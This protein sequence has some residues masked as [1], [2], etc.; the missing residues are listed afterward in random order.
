MT[1]R[2]KEILHGTLL[3]DG[4][5]EDRGTANSRLQIRHAISQ[6]AYVDWLYNE[7]KNFVSKSPRQIGEA[8][9]F[10]T[11][12]YVWLTDWRKIYYPNGIKEIPPFLSLSHLSLAVW[13]MDDGYVDQKAAYFCTHAFNDLSIMRGRSILLQFGLETGIVKDRNHYKIRVTVASTPKFIAMIKS[14]LHPSLLY[15][16][17]QTP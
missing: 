10:R 17:K 2:Q 15:K 1:Q 5:L 16:I 7:F 12:S 3:G 4:Y 13:F 8:Y 14:H 9:F 6:M 11:R